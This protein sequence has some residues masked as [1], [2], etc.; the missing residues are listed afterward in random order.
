FEFSGACAG[1]G[2]TPYIKLVTQLFGDRAFVANA[3]GC[4]SIFGGNLPTTPYTINAE[5]RGPAWSN[6]LFEDNAEFGL[7]MRMAIDQQAAYARAL[8]ERLRPLIGAALSDGLLTNDQST[9]EGINTQREL[10]AA[11]KAKLNGTFDVDA[12]DLLSVADAL[13]KKSVWIVGGDGWAYDI[14]YG[15]LDHVLA[16]GQNVNLLVLDTEVYSN[17]GGQ[18]SKATPL[19]AVAKFAA[20]GKSTGKKD[21]GMQ[22]TT[23]GH[24]YVAQVAMGASDTQTVKA[25][26]EAEAHPGPSLIIAY[27]QCIAH[28]IDMAK[29]MQQ[30]KLAVES[31]YWPLYR[32]NPA[33]IAAEK[34]PFQ[35]DSSA[36]KIPLQDYIYNEARYRMLLQS[37]P[38]TA[39]LLLGQAQAAVNQRWLRYKQLAE[40][41]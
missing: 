11:L 19:G 38:E 28:G 18:A 25:I 29:G 7:G 26:I 15:G 24:V 32:Y 22:A 35:L 14:G 5:G 36:P 9:E 30:Q 3:T 41:K 6:S 33:R 10:V 12:R 4:S 21:L 20:G 17:T 27:S 13:V 2:E 39:K 16:S 23:Y 1:C 34:N 40:Q 31:G 37:D 8:V